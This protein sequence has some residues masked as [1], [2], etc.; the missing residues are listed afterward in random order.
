MSNSASSGLLD[1]PSRGVEI[2]SEIVFFFVIIASGLQLAFGVRADYF[3]RW[4]DAACSLVALL[5]LLRGQDRAQ[6]SGVSR[7]VVLNLLHVPPWALI[8]GWLTVSGSV[9]AALLFVRLTLWGPLV[10]HL[11]QQYRGFELRRSGKIMLIA[12]TVLVVVHWVS[13]IWLFVR[14]VEYPP[15]TAYNLAVYW[16]VTTLATVGYGDITPSTNLQRIFAIGV[17]ILGVGMYGF[18]IGQITS[19]VQNSDRRRKKTVE[20]LET[21]DAFCRHYDVPNELRDEALHFYEHV[22]SQHMDEEEQAMLGGLPESLRQSLEVYMRLKPLSRV[23]L[24]RGTSHEF[25]VAV[26]RALRKSYIGPGEEIIRQGDVGHTMYLLGHGV[27]EVLVGDKH[28][29]FLRDGSCFGEIAL[30]LDEPRTATV[31]SQTHCEILALEKD[32]FSALVQAFPE[33]GSN[34]ESLVAARRGGSR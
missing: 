18:V 33:L 12:A 11:F 24:F 25:L 1:H 5:Y 10:G 7:S 9:L 2:V 22:L 19:L 34:V 28:I 8:L 6:I 17:M 21:L 16:T 26:S 20:R 15:V 4:M 32:E 23:S 29:T 31:R 14:P 3:Y 27:V 30:V 13:C